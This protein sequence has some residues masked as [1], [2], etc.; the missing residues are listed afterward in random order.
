[1]TVVL[2]NFVVLIFPFALKRRYYSF[3]NHLADFMDSL[4]PDYWGLIKLEAALAIG[5]H[6]LIVWGLEI[7][8]LNYAL[9]YFGFGFSWSAMQYV[10]HFGTERHV[11]DGARNLWFWA[12]IDLVW[13]H[14]NWHRAHHH[15][16]TVPWIYLPRLGRAENPQREWLIWHYLRMWRGPRYT[17]ERVENG[18]SGRIT[19]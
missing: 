15:H 19:H 16:P 1:M 7:P 14:H 18:Y 17:E 3:D 8:I 6:V 12:P 10:H 4:N 2:A 13:M 5:L 9:V 11:L